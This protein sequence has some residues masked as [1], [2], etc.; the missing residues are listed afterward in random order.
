M[1]LSELRGTQKELF[2][3][4]C[5]HL[6]MSDGDFVDIEKN[7]ILQMCKEME[8]N[9]R[10]TPVANF[11]DALKQLAEDTTIREKRIILLE[12]GGIILADGIFSSEEENAM[13]KI[14]DSLEIDYFQ[15]EKVIS[16]VRDL[17]EVY[18]KIGSF[19]SSK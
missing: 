19:L 18:L 7:T 4:L 2:L 15:C 17:Y 14:A 10:L 3:D 16:M 9:E 11:D 6:S 13:K 5:I 8:I 12:I 1:Y